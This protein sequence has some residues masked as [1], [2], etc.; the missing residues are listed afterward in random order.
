M[1]SGSSFRFLNWDGVLKKAIS[2][3]F[4]GSCPLLQERASFSL[5]SFGGEY[6]V[7]GAC[8]SKAACK[9][10]VFPDPQ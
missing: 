10:D 4:V 1:F 7:T 9:A 6:E 3:V 8:T 2:K 5:T